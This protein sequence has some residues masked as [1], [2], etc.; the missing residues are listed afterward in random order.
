ML[1]DFTG[2]YQNQNSFS[3]PK[4]LRVIGYST[5]MSRFQE[6]AKVYSLSVGPMLEKIAAAPSQNLIQLEDGRWFSY[7]GNTFN[8]VDDLN[9]A[10]RLGSVTFETEGDNFLVTLDNSGP[11]MKLTLLSS[12]EV[13]LERQRT[14]PRGVYSKSSRR[15]LFETTEC[16]SKRRE[17]PDEAHDP[18]YSPEFP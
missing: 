9:F 5:Y 6:T 17:W 15:S 12:G 3:S 1:D 13:G 8:R 16:P 10:K 14:S 18:N 2:C 4:Y 11:S 7:F